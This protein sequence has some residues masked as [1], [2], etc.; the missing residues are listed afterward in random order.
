MSKQNNKKDN[1]KSLLLI[2]I[3]RHKVGLLVVILLCM[4]SSTLAWF[5]Y[6]TQVETDVF[7]NKVRAWKIDVSSIDAQENKILI[8]L[9]ELYPGR[10]SIVYDSSADCD[11]ENHCITITNEGEMDGRI[12]LIFDKIMLFGEEED[13]SS[14][15]ITKKD[16]GNGE[17]Y[18]ITGYA[19]SLKFVVLDKTIY[20]AGSSTGTSNTKLYYELEWKYEKEQADFNSE[21][22]SSAEDYCTDLASFI[23]HY[24]TID[25]ALGERAYDYHKEKDP[26]DKDL[27]I[28]L[29]IN[30]SEINQP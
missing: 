16:V 12:S 3:K 20:R 19:F 10:T 7:S 8:D 1:K 2:A 23:D 26:D 4:L 27:T 14:Y 24:D 11:E 15:S 9:N 30:I 21:C 28:Q 18:L 29:R 5:T 13:S 25:T 22:E 17:E 6:N